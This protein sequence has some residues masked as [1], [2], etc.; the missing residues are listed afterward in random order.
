M[1]T[2]SYEVSLK[3]EDG[4][5]HF[6]EDIERDQIKVRLGLVADGFIQITGIAF[7]PN[8]PDLMIVLEK[9]GRASL[10]SLKTGETQ[11][12]FR[13][14]SRQLRAGLAR[15]RIRPKVWGQW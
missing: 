5:T 7:V 13:R 1:M 2:P 15:N 4:F 14:G 10:T 9:A 3:T 8:R 6:D 11:T 12:W